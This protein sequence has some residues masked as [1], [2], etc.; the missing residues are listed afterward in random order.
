VFVGLNGVVIKSHGDTDAEG[1]ASA[2]DVG[3]EMVRDGLLAKIGETVD[4]HHQDTTAQAAGG[5]AS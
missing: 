5:A 4:R 1:F 3:Y 2:V